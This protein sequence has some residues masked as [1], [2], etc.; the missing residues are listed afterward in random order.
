MENKINIES[1]VEDR[2][3]I[4]IIDHSDAKKLNDLKGEILDVK[5]YIFKSY[6]KEP[7][8]NEDGTLKEDG[9]QKI[10]TLLVDTDDQVYVTASKIFAND[11]KE[12]L[13]YFEN[14]ETLKDGFKIKIIE[15]SMTKSK[16]KALSFQLEM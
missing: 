13:Q 7:E 4:Y 14:D 9:Y 11:L 1:N 8:Y 5:E 2:K 15:K 16:N 3:R 12:L 6:Y 10:I